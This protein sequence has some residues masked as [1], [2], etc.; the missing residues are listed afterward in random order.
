MTTANLMPSPK[1]Q[2]FLGAGVPLVGGKI[3]TYQA[4]TT[5]LLAT[6]KDGG[7][8]VPQQNPIPL[9]ARGEPDSPIYWLGT[10][11]V[12]VHDALDNLIYTVDNFNSDATG[13]KLASAVGAALI[14]WS[15]NGTATTVEQALNLL[16]YGVNNVCD[17][18][19]GAVGDGVTLDDGAVQAAIN[20]CPD[21]GFV[22]FPPNKKVTL[23]QGL[24]FNGKTNVTLIGAGRYASVVYCKAMATETLVIG[25]SVALN[26]LRIQGLQFDGSNGAGAGSISTTWQGLLSVSSATSVHN[27]F[28]VDCLV[29]GSS[30][31]N[32][33][34]LNLQYCFYADIERTDVSFF[35]RAL[36]VGQGGFTTTTITVRKSYL[37]YCQILVQADSNVSDIQFYDTVFESAQVAWYG[38]RTKALFTGCYFENLGYGSAAGLPLKNHGISFPVGTLDTAIDSAFSDLYSKLTF[39]SCIFQYLANGSNLVAW[40]KGYGPGSGVG[41]RGSASF[42]DCRNNDANFAFF[43]NENKS[44]YT[45][46]VYDGGDIAFP[47]LKSEPQVRMVD[48]GHTTLAFPAPAYS[49]TFQIRGGK[50]IFGMDTGV[51][52]T[53]PP[54][55]PPTGGAFATG[56]TAWIAGVGNGDPYGYI[57]SAA[58]T[59]QVLGFVPNTRTVTANTAMS[60]ADGKLLVNF[61]GFTGTVTLP[62]AAAAANYPGK[63]Y[64]VK[65]SSGLAAAGAAINFAAGAGTTLEVATSITTA[66]GKVTWFLDGTVWRTR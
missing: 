17:P 42:R 29:M 46:C 8:T 31:A 66:F 54:A 25:A 30:A 36:W 48:E 55:A 13:S 51:A 9:N 56:D 58:G 45:Y 6:Y 63:D 27:L 64:L 24:T 57:Y 22:Y 65:D 34:G 37:H 32:A 14:G 2:L 7:A 5:T 33:A 41:Q 18:R 20:A 19:F 61:G 62:T 1:M 47:V 10:Y 15:G 52:L 23:S 39:V 59:W 50:M 40:F 4:G 26:S 35:S 12:D 11:R 60:A 49:R 21:G 53:A 3:Y 38:L 16:Y 43:G 44:G 28:I